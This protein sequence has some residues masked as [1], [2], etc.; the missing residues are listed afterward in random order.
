M[1]ASPAPVVAPAILIVDD[2]PFVLSA[3][4][5]TLEREKYHVVAVSSPLT[6]AIGKDAFWAQIELDEHRA[7]DIGRSVMV[8]NALTADAQEGMTAFVEKRAPEWSGR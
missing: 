4:K 7:Y 3:L 2:E 1:N 8:K 6:V 5:E